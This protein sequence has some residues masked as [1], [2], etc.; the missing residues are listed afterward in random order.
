M[1]K[2]KR[3]PFIKI[4]PKGDNVL[5]IWNDWL[6]CGEEEFKMRHIAESSRFNEEIKSLFNLHRHRLN[7]RSSLMAGSFCGEWD[8]CPKNLIPKVIEILE[9][10]FSKCQDVTWL[11][12]A[13]DPK[14]RN[15]YITPSIG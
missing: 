9:N 2:S 5:V 4:Y 15:K 6:V 3:Q 10:F 14:T 1:K 8:L 13:I 11:D 7:K 12:S